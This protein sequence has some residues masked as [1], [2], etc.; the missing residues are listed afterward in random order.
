MNKDEIIE[1]YIDV[2][3]MKRDAIENVERA[4]WETN[5]SFLIPGETTALNIRTVQSVDYIV[6]LF[7]SL[8]GKA[9]LFEQACKEMEVGDAKFIW[10]G[11][12]VE[13]WKKDFKTRIEKIQISKKKEEL[14]DLESRLDKLVSKEKREQ[15]ELE[16]IQ[17][18][19]DK[20]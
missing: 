8:L 14:K 10:Q 4:T 13:Q 18:T 20:M 7:A 6:S 16:A 17:R 15:M 11:F 9:N 3:Q 5:C 12:T 2:I 1:K 19:L